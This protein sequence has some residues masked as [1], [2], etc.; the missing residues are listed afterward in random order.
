MVAA[1]YSD[2]GGSMRASYVYT[3]ATGSNTTASFTPAALGYAGQVFVWNYGKSTG[4]LV[5]AS[6]VYSESV[7]SSSASSY[8]VVVPLG[9]SGIAFAGD[10]GKFVTLGKKRITQLA[11]N[12][13]LSASLV[14]AS[15]ETSVTVHGYATHQPSATARVGSVGTVMWDPAQMLFSVAVEPA[16]GTAVLTL[17]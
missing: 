10:A 3:F 15:G 16:N 17:K 6:A 13:T 8:Y 4:T 14:F 5:D 12:G 11:D 7:D 2:F 1:T 9:Q